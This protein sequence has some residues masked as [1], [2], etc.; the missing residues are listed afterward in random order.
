MP[1]KPPPQGGG[2]RT[3]RPCGCW[4][5]RSVKI[6]ALR[7]G[8]IFSRRLVRLKQPVELLSACDDEVFINYVHYAHALRYRFHLPPP[9]HPSR[10]KR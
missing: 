7:K 2:Q 10:T 5:G 6:F 3:P 9:R 4:I 8:V 1:D